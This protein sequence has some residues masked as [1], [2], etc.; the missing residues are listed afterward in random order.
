[1]QSIRTLVGSTRSCH[2]L[3]VTPTRL[4]SLPDENPGGWSWA[5][6]SP[7]NPFVFINVSSSC[8]RRRSEA[9]PTSPGNPRTSN[10]CP[11]QAL[12]QGSCAAGTTRVG[13][14][15][16]RDL[17]KSISSSKLFFLLVSSFLFFLFTLFRYRH[18]MPVVPI[19]AGG[20]IAS[21]A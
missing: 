16:R 14:L 1:M 15:N 20:L 3:A 12:R 6:S 4:A 8:R 9:N 18:G 2:S 13:E 17:G 11:R 19:G 21:C 10:S 7:L 5:I